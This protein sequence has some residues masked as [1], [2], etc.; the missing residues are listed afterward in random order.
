MLLADGLG[1]QLDARARTVGLEI[2]L[3]G[4]HDE[5]VLRFPKNAAQSLRDP[6]HF[7]RIALDLNDFSDRVDALEKLLVDVV[8]N[9]RDRGVAANLLGDQGATGCDPY[10]IDYGNVIGYA[11]YLGGCQRL[12]FVRHPAALRHRHPDVLHQRHVVAQEIVFLPLDLRVALQHFEKLLRVPGAEPGHAHHA[13][14]V[15]AHVGDLFGNVQVH[16]VD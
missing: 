16:A 9:E 13:E 4:D 6:N 15:C 3:D 12:A 2:A 8:P 11:I 7:V 5:I 14:T 1:H 10:I